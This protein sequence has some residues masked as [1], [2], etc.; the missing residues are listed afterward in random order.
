M[1]TIVG[2]ITGILMTF[3]TIA[4][5]EFIGHTVFPPPADLDWSDPD[6]LRS[7]IDT[8]PILALSFPL[9]GYLFGT[10]DG[11]FIAGVIARDRYMVHALV[12]GGLV[13]LG[14]IVNLALFPHPGWFIAA[15]ILGIPLVAFLSMLLAKKVLPPRASSE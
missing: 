4:V 12:I 10:F 9:I 8:L 1:R 14:T 11:V 7:Y 15:A 3:V 5:I 13:L 6:A 2:T